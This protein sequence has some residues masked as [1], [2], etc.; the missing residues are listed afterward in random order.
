MSAVEIIQPKM[1]VV[2]ASGEELFC[3]YCGSNFANRFSL[4]KH[5]DLEHINEHLCE[6]CKAT[7][8]SK[9]D[10]II[11]LGGSTRLV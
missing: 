9:K 3:E 6:T 10:L 11:S 5:I 7:F 2:E 8:K 1:E 4:K